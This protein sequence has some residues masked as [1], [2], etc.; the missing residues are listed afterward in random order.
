MKANSNPSVPAKWRD[1]KHHVWKLDDCDYVAGETLKQVREWYEREIKGEPVEEV[2][3]APLDMEGET[4]DIE[5]GEPSRVM[6]FAD[7]IAEKIADGQA[8]PQI[9][10][11][12]PFYA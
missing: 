5:G 4:A 7:M 8:F 6:T 12:D 1:D 11:S 10:G 9:L 3:D 2:E